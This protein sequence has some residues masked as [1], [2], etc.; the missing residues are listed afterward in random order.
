MRTYIQNS[1]EA[2][3]RIVA[4]VM[5]ADGHVC[6]NELDLIE[7]MQA[8]Q[9]SGLSRQ[10]LLAVTQAFCEDMQACSQLSWTG[11]DRIDPCAVTSL[12][13]EIDD[14]ALRR[15][16]LALCDAIVETDGHVGDGE[17]S[18]LA[19]ARRHWRLTDDTAAARPC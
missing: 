3:A 7:R 11:L 1:P 9:P 19:A 16:L 5:L 6:K 4:L 10:Q 8:L 14:P 17:S 2:A 12:F 13:A 18:M 15:R